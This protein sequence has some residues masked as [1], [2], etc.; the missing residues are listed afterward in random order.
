MFNLVHVQ[1]EIII[2]D[3]ESP[4]PILNCVN[5]RCTIFGLSGS[6]TFHVVIGARL[7]ERYFA[8]SGT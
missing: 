8:V 5:I 4:T 7:D 2:Q 3:C 6:Q 1:L